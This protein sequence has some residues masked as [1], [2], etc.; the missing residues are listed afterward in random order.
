MK[1]L[2]IK[3]FIALAIFSYSCSHSKN[4]LKVSINEISTFSENGGEPNLCVSTNG[5][6]FMSWI[7]Y[8]ND[9]TDILMFSRLDNNEWSEPNIIAEGSNWFVNWADFPS[10]KSYKNSDQYL[11]AHWLQKSDVGVYD[12][13]VRI[14]QS[15]NA[16]KT[17]KS[18]F[19]LH[20][21]NIAAEHGFVSM[22]PISDEKILAVWLDGRKTKSQLT[23]HQHSHGNGH[24][25]GPMT[26]RTAEFDIEGNIYQEMELD[27]K[28][29]DCCQTDIALTDD[30]P[31]VVYRDRS[32]TEIRD[33]SYVRKVNHTWSKPK[34]IANDNW[35]IAG[36][37]VN[38]PAIDA[39]GKVIA[40]A[41][42]TIDEDISKVKVCFS[43]NSGA[44]FEKPIE[45]SKNNPLGRLDILLLDDNSAGVSWIEEEDNQALIKF[46][47]VNSSGFLSNDH[48]IS[49]TSPDRSS[50]FPRMVQTQDQMVFAWTHSTDETKSVKAAIVE[51]DY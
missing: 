30:G 31:I 29:C 32:D 13:D 23:Q 9:S 38:G 17:W 18:S 16:G 41:W 8:K 46:R 36:C 6:V 28:V 50:G 20:N 34:S 43:F 47:I 2:S 19:I 5:E 26:L 44:S 15:T 24:S 12:Y 37:P 42:Y 25:H 33:I 45:I 11:A 10:I 35:N 39:K 4:D 1:K 51:L 14:S 40:V 49:K 21:D 48:I 22:L 7:E 3:L 27:D